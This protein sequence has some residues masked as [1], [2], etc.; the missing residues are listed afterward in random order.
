M[1]D[2]VDVVIFFVDFGVRFDIGG[3][4]GMVSG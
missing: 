3:I 4:L 2:F 1:E